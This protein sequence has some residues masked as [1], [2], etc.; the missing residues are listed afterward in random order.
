MRDVRTLHVRKR[1]AWVLVIDC[2]GWASRETLQ[3]LKIRTK[4]RI[5]VFHF[6]RILV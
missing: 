3:E 1:E 2:R 6:R 4:S 5:S